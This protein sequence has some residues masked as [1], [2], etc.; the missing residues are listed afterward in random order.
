TITK[1]LIFNESPTVNAG[2]DQTICPESSIT[3]NGS[4]NGGDVSSYTW[5]GGSGTFSPYRN[6]LNAVYTPGDDEIPAGSVQLKLS[7]NSSSPA[8]CNLV[9]DE[10]ILSINPVNRIT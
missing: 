8:P 5:L 9:E 7:V 2:Q 10:M 1:T 3:L 6:S 4:I